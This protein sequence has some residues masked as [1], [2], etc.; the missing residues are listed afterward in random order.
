MTDPTTLIADLQRV[1][2]VHHRLKLEIGR[3]VF[4]GQELGGEIHSTFSRHDIL[5]LLTKERY[6][7]LK[8]IQMNLTRD[9]T[10]LN[11]WFPRAFPKPEES[12]EG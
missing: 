12:K 1:A 5:S 4:K 2:K 6:E 9:L 7:E 3:W 11:E 8:Q 10:Q